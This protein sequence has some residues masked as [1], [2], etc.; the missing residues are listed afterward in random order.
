MTDIQLQSELASRY[1]DWKAA[2][3]T[4][5]PIP[6]G[7]L[8][9]IEI[10]DLIPRKHFSWQGTKWQLSLRTQVLKIHGYPSKIAATKGP[11]LLTAT[12]E[13]LKTLTASHLC[14]NAKCLNP[15][16]LVLETLAVNKARNGC[17]S[18]EHCFHKPRCLIPG[19]LFSS[20][21]EYVE[22]YVDNE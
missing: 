6:N 21:D 9:C 13:Q 17:P 16:H 2:I 3:K 10:R 5:H 15:K 7:E 20:S 11:F 4:A 22:A 18:C 12:P 19:P 8:Q 14:H 1:Q